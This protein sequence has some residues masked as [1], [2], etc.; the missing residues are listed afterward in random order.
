M[1]KILLLIVFLA[2]CGGGAGSESSKPEPQDPLK[3]IHIL[4]AIGQQNAAGGSSDIHKAPDVPLDWGY[5]WVGGQSFPL[6]EPTRQDSKA[7]GSAW[8][9]YAIRFH[10]LKGEPVVIVNTGIDDADIS[11]IAQ[12]AQ[13]GSVRT[14]VSSAVN[15][16]TNNGYDI[17]SLSAVFIHGE[18]DAG[19]STPIE[20]YFQSL[21]EVKSSL[22][23]IDS[24]FEFYIVRTGYSLSFN[25]TA[26]DV[27]YTLG[28]EQINRA[29]YPVSNLPVLFAQS[30][31]MSDA[32]H[33]NQEAYNQLGSQIADNVVYYIDGVD[34]SQSIKAQDTPDFR[35]N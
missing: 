3:P 15:Y 26:L 19:A 1:K 23:D 32:I 27:S 13:A 6:S 8:S 10:E 29:L 34:V 7:S 9:A 28:E 2:G 16:Y 18:S 17:K 35:C 22:K 31:E 14:L 11:K 24:M 12:E 4:V 21:N 25:C 20:Y 33:Y 30:G 5:K